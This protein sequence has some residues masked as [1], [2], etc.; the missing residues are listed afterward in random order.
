MDVVQRLG[1]IY[2]PG[3]CIIFRSCTVGDKIRLTVHVRMRY[4]WLSR[5]RHKGSPGCSAS[6]TSKR[7]MPAWEER[8]KGIFLVGL[9]RGVLRVWFL[10]QSTRLIELR[11]SPRFG[12]STS[13]IHGPSCEAWQKRDTIG[14]AAPD[15]YFAGHLFSGRHTNVSPWAW[16]CGDLSRGHSAGSGVRQ[17]S[18][19]AD[20][21]YVYLARPL[22]GTER[23]SSGKFP[24]GGN[25]SRGQRLFGLVVWFTVRVGEVPGSIPGTALCSW[26]CCGLWW[27]LVTFDI[28]RRFIIPRGFHGEIHSTHFEENTNHRETTFLGET[29]L[30]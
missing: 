21:P 2:I 26:C 7:D 28:P 25:C 1:I 12:L 14:A 16:D 9:S 4:D 24:C 19:G 15:T 30:F 10:L 22:N 20:T 13:M 18:G 8:D 29:V 27:S 17:Q 3:E 5:C 23:A 11:R 6:V